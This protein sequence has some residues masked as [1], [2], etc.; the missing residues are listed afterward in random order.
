MTTIRWSGALICFFWFATALAAPSATDALARFFSEVQSFNARFEQVV[1]D[2]GRNVL[3]E[4]SGKMWI[5]RPGKF[6]WEY[7]PPYQQL[8][9]GDGK[10]VWVYDLDLEQITVRD[11]G[12]ALGDTPAILLAGKGNLD[13]TF[14][15]KKLGDQGKLG[16]VQLLPKRTDGGFEDIRLGFEAGRL[17]I[18][19]LIDAFGQMTRITLHNAS[20]NTQLNKQR[21]VFEPPAGV[22]IIREEVQ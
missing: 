19:E 9:V 10:K 2:E 6:R 16:W 11:M 7:D 5:A 20:E 22:D 13:D 17:R 15:V 8:I 12:G 1:L 4:T 3:Q 14:V 18:L 21:F